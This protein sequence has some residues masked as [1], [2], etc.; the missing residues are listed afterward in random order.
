[1][2]KKK[3]IN[4]LS[5]RCIDLENVDILI[6]GI[7]VFTQLLPGCL[8]IKRSWQQCPGICQNVLLIQMHAIQ[9]IQLEEFAKGHKSFNMECIT[10]DNRP[11][12]LHVPGEVL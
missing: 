10:H 2:W 3:I 8:N 9:N 1:M 6:E 12:S 5:L 11:S 7:F 4:L